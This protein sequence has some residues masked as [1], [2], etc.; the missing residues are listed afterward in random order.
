MSVKSVVPTVLEPEARAFAD[1]VA[2]PPFIT[3]LGP[4]KGREVLES[5]QL[6]AR[7]ARPDLH[8]EDLTIHGPDG[9]VAV[10]MLKPTASVDPLPVILYTHGGGWVF[11]SP[12]THDRLVREL[13]AGA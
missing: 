10:R 4:E 5:V 6:E 9:Q 12:I 1:A 2:T 11:G 7:T 3:E 13:A 8:I